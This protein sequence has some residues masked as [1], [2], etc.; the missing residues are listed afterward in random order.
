MAL[1]GSAYFRVHIHESADIAGAEQFWADLAGVPVAELKKTTLKKHN[2]ATTRKNTGDAY[3]GCLAIY[4]TKSAELYRR[5]EGA[6]YGI[7]LG[8]S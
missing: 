6:W 1:L 7:V 3:R 5:V 8:A 4:V 2:P